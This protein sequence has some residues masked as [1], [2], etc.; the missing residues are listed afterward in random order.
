MRGK[1]SAA[2]FSL[3]TSRETL[4]PTASDGCGNLE[5]SRGRKA[6]VSPQAIEHH[7]LRRGAP[8]KRTGSGGCQQRRFD[9][10]LNSSPSEAYPR[11]SGLKHG[12]IVCGERSDPGLSARP[13]QQTAG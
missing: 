9:Q 6:G 3:R 1:A 10:T 7:G 12:E 11:T 4:R 8:P 2:S 5:A 13:V